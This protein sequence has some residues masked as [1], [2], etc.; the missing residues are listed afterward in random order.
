MSST[1]IVTNRGYNLIREGRF[2]LNRGLNRGNAGLSPEE[3][4]IFYTLNEISDTGGTSNTRLI[5]K[6]LINDLIKV[7]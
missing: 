4:E 3:Y 7:E 5:E 1:Y 2:S 6:L